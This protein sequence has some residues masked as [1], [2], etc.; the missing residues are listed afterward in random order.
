MHVEWN[1]F[2]N[3]LKYLY[4]ERDIV[5]VRK[6]MEE[7]GVQQHLWLRRKLGATNLFKPTTPF[8]FQQDIQLHLRSMLVQKGYLP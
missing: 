2:D 3:L 1:I 6:D 8:M 5:E 4:G 7:A